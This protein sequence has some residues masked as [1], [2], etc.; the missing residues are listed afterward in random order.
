LNNFDS[1][2][3]TSR[4][5][6]KNRILRQELLSKY[7]NVKFNDQGSKL[8]GKHLVQFLNGYDKAITALEIID[9][10]ILLKLPKLKVIS[11]YGVGLD[12]INIDSL[13][14]HGVRLGWT[15]GVNRRSV[16]EL[17]ISSS[18]SLLRNVPIANIEVKDG[19]WRQHIGRQLSDLTV[20]IIGCGNIGKD[21]V[22]LLGAF[23][24]KV[25]VYDILDFPEFY[26]KNN[27]TPV[28]VDTLLRNSDIVTLHLPLDDS[29][30]NILNK[31]RL[32]L[33]QSSAILI[34]YSRGGLLDEDEL[35]EMLIGGKLAGAALDVFN[36]EPPEN[37]K[38][39][40]LSNCLV[41]PHI[42]GSSE[43]A[44]LA[45]GRVAIS[46]LDL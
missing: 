32:N 29:T 2:A 46:G 45:M 3:V 41:T 17:V 14:V 6:S 35:L 43:E 40:N 27:V 28:G 4:S 31:D 38:L 12:M 37:N 7:K 1:V 21:L 26:S 9:N 36:K 18:I 20:G 42:G 11:K 10:D 30:K 8:S 24:S 34:N 13:K 39:I 16:S 5:F 23:G 44:I 15:G 19:L 33:M 25:L 22:E